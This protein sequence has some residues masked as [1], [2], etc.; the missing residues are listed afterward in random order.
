[1]TRV[2]EREAREQALAAARLAPLAVVL[3]AEPGR[4]ECGDPVI[5]GERG[6]V[7]VDGSGYS[8]YLSMPTGKGLADMLQKIPAKWTV[9]QRGATE[10]A[11]HIPMLPDKSEVKILKK[12]LRIRRKRAVSTLTRSRLA[13]A[14]A[15]TRFSTAQEGGLLAEKTII[16][17]QPDPM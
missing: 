6:S 7:H 1:M 13:V 8:T 4:D 10:V 2:E 14:G 12:A 11:F 3:S 9:R 16:S 15:K 17:L 5:R